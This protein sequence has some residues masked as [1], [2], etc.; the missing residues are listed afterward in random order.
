MRNSGELTGEIIGHAAAGAAVAK[1]ELQILLF[2]KLV[3]LADIGRSYIW[4]SGRAPVSASRDILSSYCVA[5]PAWLAC[6]C[7]P[8]LWPCIWTPTHPT[9]QSMPK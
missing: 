9:I 7:C 5:R 8:S 4:S 6:C 2:E 1:D 3:V